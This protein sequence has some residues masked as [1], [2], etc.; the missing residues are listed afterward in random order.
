MTR[1]TTYVMLKSRMVAGRKLMAGDRVPVGLVSAAKLKQL[2]DWSICAD[3]GTSIGEEKLE[4]YQH[5]FD[6][7]D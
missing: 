3:T 1:L 7:G 6:K 4:K 5:T 2:C